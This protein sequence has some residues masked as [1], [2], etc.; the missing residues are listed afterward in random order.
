MDG[1]LAYRQCHG[2][3][4]FELSLLENI[5]GRSGVDG[6]KQGYGDPSYVS[7]IGDT[8]IDPRAR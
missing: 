1:R 4:G 8:I 2:I 5:G 3:T 7:A 6:Y